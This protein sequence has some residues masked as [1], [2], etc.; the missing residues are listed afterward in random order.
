MVAFS[1]ETQ[2]MFQPAYYGLMSAG[3]LLLGSV[4]LLEVGRRISRRRESCDGEAAHIGLGVVEGAV[5]SLLGLLIAFTFS[6]AA[7]RF[8]GRRQM[9]TEEA[10]DIGTAYLRINLLP[11]QAQ[12]AV[13]QMFRTYVD[14]R[15]KTYRVLPDLDAS[16]AEL[17]HSKK[18]QDE[19]W[20]YSVEQCGE[21]VS[22][23]CNMLFLPALNT[24]FDIVTTRAEA[25]KIHPPPIIFVMIIVLALGAALLAGYGMGGSKARSWLH[26]LGFA[27][28]MAL[29][30][31]VIIDIEYPRTGLISVADSDQ[32]IVEVRESMK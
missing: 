6:G 1:E 13:R 29:T 32:V 12:P 10:N 4:I 17:A 19:I 26:I 15:L 8:D 27:S 23:A 14:S 7:T 28:V 2:T 9:V 24:M 31:Y 30:V 21:S 3:I 25:S 16:Y 5:F 18:I 22:P 20:A 11:D